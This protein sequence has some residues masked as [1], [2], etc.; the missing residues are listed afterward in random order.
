MMS[1]ASDIRYACRTLKAQ[2]AWALAAILCVAIGTGANT[3]FF[4]IVNGVLLRPLQF[5]EPNQLVMVAIRP[6]SRPQPRPFSLMEFR[7][8][9]PSDTLPVSLADGNSTAMAQGEF[10]TGA[11]FKMLRI[12]PLAGRFF[13][14][15]ADHPGAAVQAVMSERL[16]RRRFGRDFSVIGPARRGIRLHGP[17]R[18]AANS[19]GDPDVRS[20]GTPGARRLGAARTAAVEPAS[21]RP[22]ART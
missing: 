7:A 10:V 22:A 3:A 17:G 21:G 18:I 13:S 19:R 14:E 15:D 20:H 8:M 1:L 6:Q 11:Y 9:A 5:D 4:S 2:P 12:Q 16:W